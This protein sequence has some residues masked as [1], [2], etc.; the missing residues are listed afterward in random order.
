MN[1]YTK[2]F[3]YAFI[4]A[5]ATSVVF[6]ISMTGLCYTT[7]DSLFVIMFTVFLI[8]LPFWIPESIMDG[9]KN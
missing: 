9:G 1:L 7:R 4:M 5:A 3:N 2:S 6:N 8:T